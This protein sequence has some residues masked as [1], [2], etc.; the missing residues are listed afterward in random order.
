MRR[1]LPRWLRSSSEPPAFFAHD[2]RHSIA[3]RLRWSYL[4]SST[5][6]LLLVGGL[7]LFISL[8]AQQRTVFNEQQ[9]GAARVARDI[10]RYISGIERQIETFGLLVRPGASPPDLVLAAQRLQER[11]FPYLIDLAVIGEDGRE[12]FR[13]YSLQPISRS[14][15]RDLSGDSGVLRAL[16]QNVT[17]FTPIAPNRDNRLTFVMTMPLRND[18]GA[19]I[20]ALRAEISAD[21]II[22]DLRAATSSATSYAYLVRAGDGIVMIDDGQPGFVQPRGIVHLLASADGVAE[23]VGARGISVVG[24]AAPIT[25]SA[26]TGWIVVVEQPFTIAFASIGRSALLLT[27]LVALVGTVALIWAFRA[28]R[29]LTQPLDALRTGAMAIGAGH[30]D[31]RIHASGEDELAEVARTFDQM[32]DHL[33]RSLEAIERQN[34][35]LRKDLAL[36]RDIQ[37]GLLP[38]RPPWNGDTMEVYARSIPAYDVGG[39]FYTFLNLSEGR[40]AIAIGDI[41]GKGVAAALLMALTSSAVESQGRQFEHPARVLTALNQL[42]AP[43]LKANHMN[44]ALLYAVFD[45]GSHTVR[46]ANAGMIAP[47]LVSP[48]SCRMIDIGGLPIGAFAGAIYQEE[49]LTVAPGDALVLVS[50]GVVEAHDPHGRLF[51]FDTFEQT[52]G[53]LNTTIDVRLLAELIINRV[54]EHMAGAEQHDDITVVVLRPSMTTVDPVSHQEDT[55]DYV[56]I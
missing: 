44:A 16:R 18:A 9:N 17:S 55:A 6:P 52:C 47:M 23:Y 31:Y 13:V 14:D 39:D 33:Q 42:L 41:S 20:G 10:I 19:V 26:P 7:L 5:L 22:T 54:H 35:S 15:L 3:S 11:I 30:L 45:P 28:A 46:V 38:D 36:A 50:D 8:S 27:T 1:M 53:T 12:Q 43:R 29:Q 21:P 40:I 48:G 25:S 56:V 32:A 4:I 37:L 49:T 51:G 2:S 24:A 34:A